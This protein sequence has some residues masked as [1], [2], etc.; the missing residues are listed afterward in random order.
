MEQALQEIRPDA[1]QIKTKLDPNWEFWT[2]VRTARGLYLNWKNLSE[3]LLRKLYLAKKVL[4]DNFSRSAG[5]A[6]KG[7]HTWAEFVKVS[8]EEVGGPCLK[9]VDNYLRRYT[10]E[11]Y[12]KPPHVTFR[13]IRDPKVVRYVEHQELE[14]EDTRLKVYV[15]P[16]DKFREI[17]IPAA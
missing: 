17:V 12:I 5:R 2:S 16:L 11:G 7:E 1:L 6:K 14:N 4:T 3:E 15:A 13:I 9:T 8:L 10:E